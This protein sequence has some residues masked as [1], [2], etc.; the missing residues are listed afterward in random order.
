MQDKNQER[1]SLWDKITIKKGISFDLPQSQW[2]E[3]Q[4]DKTILIDKF[5]FYSSV[6]TIKEVRLRLSKKYL[7]II[8]AQK[9]KVKM[10]LKL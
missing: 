9:D 6:G 3:A 5:D 4:K 10:V 2:E 1:F 8:G 7:S